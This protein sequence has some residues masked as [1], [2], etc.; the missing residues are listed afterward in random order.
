MANTINNDNYHSDFMIKE[1]STHNFEYQ[2]KRSRRKSIG[3]YV[4]EG[5]VEVRAP[6]YVSNTDIDSWV[7]EKADW[8]I[9]RINEQ[10][11]QEQ[12][13]PDISHGGN[14]LFLGE[15]REIEFIQ[16][17]PAIF[18]KEDKII[19]ARYAKT[20]TNKLL[21][22]WLKQEAQFYL[23][24]RVQE[25][26]ETMNE[27]GNINGIQFRKTRSKWGHCTSRGILQFN[28]LIIMAP[29]EVIDYLIIHELSHLKHMNHSKRFWLH[30]A[31]YCPKHKAHKLWLNNNGHKLWL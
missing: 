16:G 18:E 31:D 26:A 13:K 2:V 12:E 19:I 20:N 15:Q 28:W 10:V 11:I 9:E 27:S 25:L 5:I 4:K 29:P 17:K 22:N 30:V 1:L 6:H 7:I 21:E 14:F 3:L 23:Q 24:D 8:V